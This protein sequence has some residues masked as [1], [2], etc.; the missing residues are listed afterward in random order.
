[1]SSTTSAMPIPPRKTNANTQPTI[2]AVVLPGRRPSSRSRFVNAFAARA[3]G[4]DLQCSR[5]ERSDP[6]HAAPP[7]RRWNVHAT[8]DRFPAASGIR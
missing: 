6:C 2:V 7:R 5:V 8:D 1:M 3:V 4:R